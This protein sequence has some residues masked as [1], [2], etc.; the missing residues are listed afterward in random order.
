MLRLQAAPIHPASMVAGKFLAL[1]LLCGLQLGL[2]TLLTRVL[3]NVVWG[4]VWTVVPTILV[5]ATACAG[6]GG[7]V[8]GLAT[9]SS[10]IGLFTLALGVV[11]GLLGGSMYP[12]ESLAGPAQVLSYLTVNRWAIEAL[13]AVAV[14]EL[15]LVE[16][17]PALGW[18]MLI[19]VVGL[20]FGVW[21]VMLRLRKE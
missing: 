6:V 17:A 9:R 15:G 14:P 13:Q 10:Q 7:I 20:G 21:R 2:F 4:P 8:I 18:L 16:A 5:V 1:L 3:F 11:M 19:G 12:I